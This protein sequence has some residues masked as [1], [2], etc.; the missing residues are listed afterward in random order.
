MAQAYTRGDSLGIYET[1]EDGAN[2]LGGGRWS[3]PQTGIK[4]ITNTPIPPIVITAVSGTNGTG[5]GRLT[6]TGANTIQWTAPGDTTAGTAVTINA[7]ES[8]LLEGSTASK[9]IRVF[10]DSDYSSDNLGGYDDVELVKTFGDIPSVAI[11]SSSYIAFMLTNQ[12]ALSQDITNIKI[13]L[14][15]LGTQR[16][17]GTAQLGASGSGTITTA[18]TN[19]FA[20][21]PAYG[22]AH[23]K[24]SGGTTREIVYYTSRTATSLTVPSGGRGLLGTTAAAGSATDTIDAVPPIK[25]AKEAVD[26]NNKIQ[27]IADSST[28]PTGVTWSTATT[29]ATGITHTPL[30]SSEN[31]GLWYCI[32]IPSVAIGAYSVDIPVHLEFTVGGST[33]TNAIRF[34]IQLPQSSLDRYELFAGVDANPTFTTAATTSAT[35]PFTYALSAPPS[36]T[37]EHRITVRKRNEYNLQSFNTYYRSFVLNSSGAL[38]GSEISAPE[39]TALTQIGN[40]QLLLTSAYSSR[41]DSS[42]ANKWLLYKTTDGTDPLL[43]TPVEIETIADP[44]L[45]T[46]RSYLR[47]EIPAAEWNSTVKIV[48]RTKRTSDGE[49]SDNTNVVQATIDTGA[50][51]PRL[52]DQFSGSKYGAV[53]T[54]YAVVEDWSVTPSVYSLVARG[55]HIFNVDGADIIRAIAN[56]KAGGKIYI[57]NAL[58]LVNAT[59]SGAGTGNVEVV[60]ATEIYLVVNGT[61]RCKIDLTA[62]T[63]SAETFFYNGTIDDNPNTGPSD[64]DNDKLYLS[65]LNPSRNVWEPFL[66]VDATGTVTFA[67]PII[68]KDS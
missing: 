32:E 33:Y 3:K 68:Q 16:T 46:G 42:P 66:S 43:A 67:Y 4:F 7:N 20:D 6:A 34:M 36:G 12:N 45:I 52:I 50:P 24:T 53:T 38:V 56:E 65:L 58:S 59:I 62:N 35:L 44:D 10:R 30:V 31:L 1:L 17:T 29:S 22:W 51:A 15:T 18:T 64:T 37:R 26:S 19:G 57:D 23:I 14:G 49:I 9:W 25:I 60:S 47:Y 54:E 40:G 39:G 5:T 8:V 48:L 13:W 21:W 28:A 55:A 27:T 11:N 63:I 61:R 2:A 41:L